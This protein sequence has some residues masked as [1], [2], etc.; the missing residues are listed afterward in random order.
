MKNQTNDIIEDLEREHE[1]I[2][3]ITGSMLYASHYATKHKWE[4]LQKFLMLI[5]EFDRNIHHEKE[6]KILFVAFDEVE[7]DINSKP[8]KF[9]REEHQGTEEFI[10]QA[11]KI[12]EEQDSDAM[13]KLVHQLCHDT[14]K[15]IDKENSVIFREARGR[16]RGK[17]LQ[18]ANDKLASYNQEHEN[19][20]K[21][22]WQQAQEL[23]E[24]YPPID[25]LDDLIRSDGCLVCDNYG[26][27]CQGI[28]YEWWS[29][30]EW[31][32]F[33]ARNQGE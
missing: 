25:E 32:D 18:K 19:Q 28:E 7:I 10:V 24:K 5:K 22:L 8:L 17:T 31:E 4:D 3:Q 23:I 15:H 20:I 12:I 6:E 30:L 33:K 9:L 16:I 11:Q 27:G 26:L 21:T 14:W 1:L 13:T 29:E 2:E